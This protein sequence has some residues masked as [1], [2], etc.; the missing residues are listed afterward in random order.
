MKLLYSLTYETPLFG[1][2]QKK[3]PDT[4]FVPAKT[5]EDFERECP[6]CDAIIIAGSFYKQD[7]ADLLR[8]S[9]KKL[10]WIQ[11]GSDGLDKFVIPGVPDGV[12][13]TN[14]SGTKGRTI[15]EHAIGL[16]LSLHQ[17][18]PVMERIRQ[19]KDWTEGRS[20][21]R[22]LTG[23]IEGHTIVQLGYGHIGKEI[24]RKAKAFDAHVIALNR[25][26]TGDGAA[27][28]ILSMDKLHDVL[29]KADALMLCMP[30]TK[31][32][33]GTIGKAEL[34]LLK[35]GAVIVNVARGELTDTDGMVEALQNGKLAGAGLDVI[36]PEPLPA[37]HALWD[38][39]NVIISPHV[40][41]HGGPLYERLAELYAENIKRFHNGETL[42]NVVNLEDHAIE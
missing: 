19:S 18:I 33:R 16:L 11:A 32:T 41:G 34:A 6:D 14:T 36:E 31:E 25:S 30:F 5:H 8:K 12:V 15:G 3:Y 28:E 38:L 7:V 9:A 27:D 2:L 10:R 23:S 29:P 20:V 35:P 1:E 42:H 17:S 24:A 39:E 37:D 21:M 13:V 4:Q 40:A 22:K 26:G